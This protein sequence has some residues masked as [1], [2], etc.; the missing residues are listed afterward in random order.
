M[1]EKSR[2]TGF[3][4][5]MSQIPPVLPPIQAASS[6]PRDLYID[7]MKRCLTHSLWFEKEP[8]ARG[9][10]FSAKKKDPA[11]ALREKVEGRIWP[12]FAHTMIGFPRLNNLEMCVRSVI[13]DKIPG[14]LI[15][16]GVWRGGSCIFMRAILKA[17]GITDRTVWV[18]D[19]FAGLPPPDVKKA[20]QDKGNKLYK[21]AELAIPLETVK[22]HFQLYGLLD[23]QVEFLKGWF[24][25]TLPTAPVK[26]L[27]VARLD[28]DMYES[29]MD[30]ISALYPKLSV[31]GYLIVD[32]YESIRRCREAIH[33][34]RDAH[35][36]TEPIVKIDW[37][38]VYWRRER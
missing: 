15:E 34:Y 6:Q 27:A 22:S 33:D 14:D 5:L 35:K 10:L 16:T 29:T 36:I 9:K 12:Q 3:N 13:E 30:A 7:L 26:K 28:G 31:G 20:P 11:D 19:S 18:A 8:P 38:G 2:L 1:L 4:P 21:F 32:D 24:K 37:S 17:Y 23:D 25:D